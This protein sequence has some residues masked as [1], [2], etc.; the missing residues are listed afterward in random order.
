MDISLFDFYLPRELIAQYP[1]DK[2]DSSRMMVIE[3]ERG[4]IIHDQFKK[5]PD[6]L[7]KDDLLVLNNSKVI[8]AKIFIRD[9]NKRRFEILLLREIAGETWEVLC[10]GSKRL[11]KGSKFV[12]E[13]T[14]L[15]G[16]VIGDG[17]W[18]KKY[19]KFWFEK[20]ELHQ[21]LKSFGYAPL[22]PYIKRGEGN[23]SLREKDLEFY[24]TIW[25]KVD[26]SIAAPTAGLHFTEEI[27]NKIKGKGIEVVE[28]TLHVGEASFRPV[29]I[30]EIEKH[31]MEEE[32]V[33]IND[34]SAS[35]IENQ[36]ER[37]GR[38]ISI[39]TT[40]VRALESSFED[41]K[42]RR[43]GNLTSL[44]IYPPFKFNVVSTLFTN[45]HLPK[46][47]LF[48]LVSAFT[49]LDLMKK[50]YSEAIEKKYKFFSYGDCMLI[51]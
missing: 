27:L 18:G 40:V 37:G 13:G 25:A 43:G 51:L 2:R 36:M 48:M 9:G 15:T 5:F 41:G 47:T 3:R 35:K 14:F 21:Y 44:F 17:E 33:F 32:Y 34:F 26:G 50:A 12:L 46:S 6:Y 38:I 7:R 4:K 23:A 16:E 45:F 49:G 30:R 28:I 29:R 22:P 42:I 39:G 20:N 19:L 10:K 1:R 31:K 8:P 11:K 24:Q